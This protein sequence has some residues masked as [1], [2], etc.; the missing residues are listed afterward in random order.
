MVNCVK[1]T[2]KNTTLNVVLGF[3]KI[4]TKCVY[5]YIYT[6]LQRSI[7]EKME[8]SRLRGY[9]E[10]RVRLDERRRENTRLPIV[11]EKQVFFFPR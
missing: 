11:W 1:F 6:A 8:R 2:L 4:T 10:L 7:F 9:N 5:I 3:H